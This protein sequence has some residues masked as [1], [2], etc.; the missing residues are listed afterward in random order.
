MTGR[1]G[2]Q[3]METIGGSSVTY[4]ARTP[5]VPLFSTSFNRGGNRRAFRLPGEGGDHFHCTVEPSPSHIRCR[6]SPPSPRIARYVLPP[7]LSG[8]SNG[9]FPE[10]GGSC[11]SR[12]VPQPNV[13]TGSEAA[14]VI[15]KNITYIK[16]CF[17]NY[18]CCQVTIT[19]T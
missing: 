9:G 2:R 15:H 14:T 7:Y 17:A 19:I 12:F 5:C 4:L 8:E 10:G 18:F 6:I 16:N 13:A 11:N 1:P 3:T